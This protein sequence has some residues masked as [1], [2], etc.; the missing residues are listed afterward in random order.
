MGVA[1]GEPGHH[2]IIPPRNV[3][4]NMDVRDLFEGVELYL[5]IEVAGALFSVGDT[6]A[7]QGAGEVCGTAIESPIDVS[8]KIE[9]IKNAP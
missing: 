3:G 2:S 5:P 9:L 6:H 1:P 8:L 7:T 4:G